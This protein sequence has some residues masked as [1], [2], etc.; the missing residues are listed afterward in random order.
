MSRFRIY[1]ALTV[2]SITLGL[3][4]QSPSLVE[5]QT[6][7]TK[8]TQAKPAAASAAQTNTA[9]G[10]K[11]FATQGCTT[12]HAVGGVGGTAGPDLTA[13][14]SN[15]IHTPG[16]LTD[17]IN[18]PTKH[19][20]D[21]T[22]PAFAGKIKPTDMT[23]LVG[24]LTTLK[25]SSASPNSTST[26]GY[27][28]L[29]EIR[30]WAYTTKQAPTEDHV[31]LDLKLDKAKKASGQVVIQVEQPMKM[32]YALNLVA[33]PKKEVLA[34]L[35]TEAKNEPPS[36]FKVVFKGGTAHVDVDGKFNPGDGKLKNAHLSIEVWGIGTV[37]Q[38]GNPL[39]EMKVG[40]SVTDP[41][42]KAILWRSDLK[43]VTNG[44]V[45]VY[46]PD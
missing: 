34:P 46:A 5:S 8:K 43:K 24:Y 38:V 25:V 2:L 20:A 22:M 26:G 42:T 14:A 32:F 18:K 41:A 44:Y 23:A 31:N 39:G 27:K 17:H 15:P 29:G 3:L 30:A 11:V 4:A 9:A 10:K 1:T 12:C 45:R 7:K 21:S 16:W 36:N 13:V 40:F 33:L 6:R 35:K 37:S 28:E 19:K